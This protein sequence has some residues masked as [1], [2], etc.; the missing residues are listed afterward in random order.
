MS[1]LLCSN[2]NTG[3]T[4]EKFS[5]QEIVSL[6]IIAKS[7]IGLERDGQVNLHVIT[8]VILM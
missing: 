7:N 4:E 2:F 1:F 6:D 5:I 3:S 8:K